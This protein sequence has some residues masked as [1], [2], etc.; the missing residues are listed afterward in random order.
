[1]DILD[2]LIPLLGGNSSGLWRFPV[3]GA[4]IHINSGFDYRIY[5]DQVNYESIVGSVGIM[6]LLK[7]GTLLEVGC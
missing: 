3:H 5:N 6:S 2:D 4:P 1:M 7:N